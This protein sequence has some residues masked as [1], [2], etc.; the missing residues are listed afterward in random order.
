M[1]GNTGT[2]PLKVLDEQALVEGRKRWRFATLKTRLQTTSARPAALPSL[3]SHS[4]V[5]QQTDKHDTTVSHFSAI[6][7]TEADANI[8][9]SFKQFYTLVHPLSLSL[10]LVFRNR[11]KLINI[12]LTALQHATE[13]QAEATVSVARCLTAIFV[14]IGPNFVHPLFPRIIASFAS[15]LNATTVAAFSSAPNNQQNKR[16]STPSILWDPTTS[17]I[18]LFASLAEITRLAIH[19]LALHPQ[20]TVNSLLPLLCHPHFRIREMTAE[21]CLGYL[22]R[23]TRDEHRLKRLTECAALAAACSEIPSEQHHHAAHG[24]G[25]S[26]FEA[27]RAPSGRLHSRSSLV[28]TQVLDTLCLQCK[29]TENNHADIERYMM[30][31]YT[32]C[33]NLS[34]YI[35]NE[36]DANALSAV[37]VT[38]GESALSESNDVA[39]TNVLYLLRKWIQYGGKKLS[40][41]LGLPFLQRILNLLSKCVF[42]RNGDPRICYESLC[43]MCSASR[44]ASFSFSHKTC[45]HVI[46][47]ALSKISESDAPEAMKAALCV[48]LD[49]YKDD[50]DFARLGALAKGVGSLC[51]KVASQ[52]HREM[53]ASEDF[54]HAKISKPA[55]FAALR[56]L[57]LRNLSRNWQQVIASGLQCVELNSQI[58]SVLQWYAE[59]DDVLT[60]RTSD[61]DGNNLLRYVLQY[62][63]SVHVPAS[64]ELLGTIAAK[65]GLSLRW[66]ADTLRAMTYQLFQS[67]A[68]ISGK[69]HAI[70]DLVKDILSEGK[71]KMLPP[72]ALQALDFFFRS[73]DVGA[74]S[75]EIIRDCVSEELET[76]LM[77]GLSSSD[78]AVRIASASNLANIAMVQRWQA[79]EQGV[80]P[81]D[82][83]EEEH[84]AHELLQL[85]RAFDGNDT[86]AKGL[87]ELMRNIF[88][89]TQS[90]E[91]ISAKKR[92]VQEILRLVQNSRSVSTHLLKSIVHFSIGILRTPLRLIWKDARY[93]LANAVDRD[94]K[95]AMNIVVR[96]LGACS[97]VVL[98]YAQRQTSEEDEVEDI[99]DASNLDER[100]NHGNEQPENKGQSTSEERDQNKGSPG[101]VG[102]KRSTA[103][104]SFETSGKR[105]RTSSRAALDTVWHWSA[106]ESCDLKKVVEESHLFTPC[107]FS[108][109]GS[110][111]E[112]STTDAP[113]VLIELARSLCDVPKHTTKYRTDIISIYLQLDRH[114]FSQRLGGSISHVF[115]NLLEKMGGL[116]C[117][118]SNKSLEDQMRERLLSDL[119]APNSEL[120]GSVLRCLCASRSPWI[121]PHRDSLI[122]L[123][124]SA[125]FREEL[126][127]I[128]ERLF[129]GPQEL[130]LSFDQK[131]AMVDVLTRICFSKMQ[132]KMNKKDSHRSAALSFLAS[133]LP[134][135]IA[136]PKLTSLILRPLGHVISAL[137]GDL[138]SKISHLEMPNSNVQ[139]AILSSIEA[140][141]KN[142]R[143]S[144]QPASWRKLGIGALVILR[145]AGKGSQGQSIRSRS[146]K[147]C[148]AMHLSRPAE[149]SILTR[150]VME[151]LQKAGFSTEVEKKTTRGTPALMRYIGAVMEANGDD[152]KEEVVNRHSWAIEYCFAIMKGS[153]VGVEPLEASL[154]VANGFL[155]FCSECALTH[156][157]PSSLSSPATT[158]LKL[159]GS[160]LR[161]L[162]SLLL[163]KAEQGRKAQKHWSKTYATSLSALEKLSSISVVDVTVM[164]PVA[165]ALSVSLISGDAFP[166]STSIP[167]KALS[168]IIGRA[169]KNPGTAQG[170]ILNSILR[171]IPIAAE[172]RIT[173]DSTAY[174]ALCDLLSA[175]GLPDIEAASQ[176]LKQMH[177]MQSS[178]LDAPDLDKRIQALN[179]LIRV[180]KRG[181]VNRKAC[182]RL[183]QN[184]TQQPKDAS[185]GDAQSQEVA[186]SSNALIALFCGACAAVRSEDTAVRG[187]GGYAIMLMA[188]WAGSSEHGSALALRT[189]IFKYLLQATIA[190]RDQTY[191]REYCRALGE[192]V[193]KTERLENSDDWDGYTSF[194]ILKSL[195]SSEDVNADFFEN[196]VH[197]QAHRRGR[198]LRDLEKSLQTPKAEDPE[199]AD[200]NVAYQVFATTFCLPLGMNLAMESMRNPDLLGHKRFGRGSQAKEDA[201]RDVAVWAVS[202]VRESAK[203]LSWEEYKKCLSTVL[204]RLNV[205]SS[206]QVYGVLYKLLVKISE[207]YPRHEEGSADYDR[208]SN[209]LVEFVLPRMLKHV[210][211][212]AVEGNILQVSDSQNLMKNRPAANAFQ[213][214]VATAIA[215]LMTRLPNGMLDT[216]IPLLITPMTN[217]LRSRMTGIRDSAKKTLTSVVLIL[218]PKYLGYILKQVLSGLS[219]GFRRDTCIY[220]VHSLLSGIFD[221]KDTG[222]VSFFLDD[223]YDI[224]SGLLI[225]ELKNGI[226]EERRDYE[227][228]NSSTSRLRQASLRAAKA[229]GCAEIIATHLS[230]KEHA[231]RFC[232]PFLEIQAGASSSKLLNRMQDFWRHVVQGFSKNKTMN[233][234]DSFILCYKIISRRT[235]LE[236]SHGEVMDNEDGAE[237]SERGRPS[238]S[239]NYRMSKVGLQILQSILTKNWPLISGT[240]D[241]SRRLQ[242]MCEPFCEILVSA[243]K[244]GRDDLTIMVFRV[245]QRLLKLPLIG[246][247]EMGSRLSET[248]VDVLS[249]G[250]NAIS[251]TGAPD[252]EDSLFITCLRAAAVLLSEL[253]TQSFKV[254]P[255]DRVEALIS[256][257]VECIDSGGPEV[258][259]AALSV[260]RSLVLGEVIIP[261][262]Y[263]AM[264]K[265]NHMA[266]HC[267][268]RQLRN[269]CTALSVTF[270]VSFPLGSKRVRQQLEFFVRNLSYKLPEGRLG[271]LNAINMVV[272]KFPVPVLEKE[273]EYLFVALASM[274]SRDADSQC[275][276]EASQCLRLLFEKLPAGRKVAD[277]LRMAVA[278]SG[279]K[280]SD[281]PSLE[282]HIKVED[283]DPVIQRSGASSM[284]AAC[285]SGNLSDEQITIVV[286]AAATL[287]PGLSN[288]PGWETAHAFLVC[289]EEAFER[290]ALT[291]N[292]QM[293][294][295]KFVLP[296]W[297]S[298]P[299]FLLSKHQWVRLSAAR[300]LRRHLSSAGGRHVDIQDP[301]SPYTV[302]SSDDLVRE[303]LRSC[304]LQ[305]EAN[306]LSPELARQV[307]NNIMCMADV[308]KRNPQVGD[309]RTRDAESET[310]QTHVSP[311]EEDSDR[312]EGRALTWLIARMSGIAMKGRFESSDVLRRGCALR[313]LIVTSKWWDPPVIK[314]HERQYINA[315][316]KVLESGDIRAASGEVADVSIPSSNPIKKTDPVESTAEESGLTG[317]G[318]QLLAQTLQESLTEVLGTAEYYKVYNQLRSKREEV[319]QE[320]KRKAALF[321]AVDP[322]RAAKKRRKKADA[323]KRKKKKSERT[324]PN[325]VD[326]V[327][328]QRAQLTEGL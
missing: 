309:L 203:Y 270:L 25:V 18:P 138:S 294:L 58:N 166:I 321:A 42:E 43:A 328:N 236:N 16:S 200:T 86:F 305:L 142:C 52:T 229:S 126:A 193:R 67:G 135:D 232:L 172:P 125:S 73:S 30:V 175:L 279:L 327:A 151:A 173:N 218:G 122:R 64:V 220:V 7:A 323:K 56:F 240:S 283:V 70:F 143:M 216:T 102:L 238:T 147:L 78:S 213:A 247:P 32:C 48:V 180:T 158:L 136:F 88:E 306:I 3:Q 94:D 41:L 133:K 198:A 196:L 146:L 170:A 59:K 275:R 92:H 139:K 178:K 243:L 234:Q 95:L 296:L 163:S 195:A 286:R 169:H 241:E 316:V 46:S 189:H 171:L 105:R 15:V 27:V 37:F 77:E 40:D 274:V 45:R 310:L 38:C 277:L 242:A 114:L 265:V 131:E 222:N 71:D 55:L 246:R 120:Q 313:F 273:C 68:G 141:V 117:C 123:T 262:L 124:Q 75:S 210:T 231:E 33:S 209:Y 74:R 219:E 199:D 150:G 267:Q 113:T 287:L 115:T 84:H 207:A 26:L 164:V 261:A 129:S 317:Q 57:E 89:T 90:M 36:K 186:C 284:T 51:D 111:G 128:T 91:K 230:F 185:D 50:W 62:L 290:S 12:C 256:V 160:S 278:L 179:E 255:R 184:L 1:R 8:T 183:V 65:D 285:M 152:A 69:D 239:D 289:V 85:Q 204:R 100:P 248:I 83:S 31:V 17:L 181:L 104:S 174:A 245:S 39:L 319:K 137:E 228:P 49:K 254:V 197:L 225:E 121:K 187:N 272:N 167:L 282:V 297:K 93:L 24:L 308:L 194:P 14:D 293:E 140:V 107:C 291:A 188:Q 103:G 324:I 325:A 28:M 82:N 44:H 192:F 4:H 252:T 97:D 63:S 191:R 211:S 79:E 303:I 157:T 295:Q 257:S 326:P 148:S 119:T 206:E 22:I 300:L 269:A 312:T 201:K 251:S 263:D 127:L 249:H 176:L 266:I 149:T 224:V 54:E 320:R 76:K 53:P 10:P 162:V 244:H 258:R 260:L 177:A 237:I 134:G 11:K 106:P 214:P 116:K 281:G 165:E 110:L 118:E 299:S 130:A 112:N 304:S 182:I 109:N 29:P 259:M 288:V 87:F 13:H 72:S 208:V 314:R 155:H 202:L 227:D 144:L 98:S 81:D 292:K 19:V 322:E 61:S 168:G 280:L 145:N 35:S 311:C 159:L 21:S 23:K 9:A 2:A 96:K 235:L 5:Q 212:G 221:S 80:E 298:L 190:S 99:N 301:M 108:D 205:E 223:I 307:L 271:A 20:H 250:S 161:S 6:L 315:V 101:S 264:T 156:S 60:D 34:R 154:K 66:K 253:G 215:Q 217:A 226:N 318:L 132:G 153:D 233:V 47:P 302:W 268:S 276:S